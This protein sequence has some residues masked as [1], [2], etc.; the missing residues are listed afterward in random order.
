[1]P[2]IR[3]L[4]LWR[5]WHHRN[6][7]MHGNGRV[8]VSESVEFLKSYVAVLEGSPNSPNT[9]ASGKGKEKVWEGVDP[10]ETHN[11]SEEHRDC[12]NGWVPPKPGWVK[13]NVDAGFCQNSELASIGVVVRD[14]FME[15]PGAQCDNGGASMSG[16]HV[17]GGELGS[18]AY[19]GLVRNKTL[20]LIEREDDTRSWEN[21]L[22][23][24]SHST[25]MSCSP[26]GWRYILI[27][28]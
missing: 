19:G 3:L 20:T 13:A 8:I 16:G 10:N 14:L 21:F 9:E 28:C 1:M 6:N 18:T 15:V 24:L 5:A 11:P 26:R 4:L 25:T 2:R 22:V 7:I 12:H 17:S 27:G 23:Y